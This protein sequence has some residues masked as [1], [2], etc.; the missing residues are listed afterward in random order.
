MA[1]ILDQA[2][3]GMGWPE[4]ALI[5]GLLN[6]V[7][8]VVLDIQQENRM[9][10]NILIYGYVWLRERWRLYNEER[11]SLS[12]SVSPLMMITSSYAENILLGIWSFP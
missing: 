2:L 11:K 1:Q 9:K 8:V 10:K 4:V 3:R 6:S 5:F 7:G 12:F